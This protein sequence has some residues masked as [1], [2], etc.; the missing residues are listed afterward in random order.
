[1]NL[2]FFFPLNST[3]FSILELIDAQK[4]KIYKPEN[5]YNFWACVLFFIYFVCLFHK[6]KKYIYM[7]F[8]TNI[9]QVIMKNSRNL[10]IGCRLKKNKKFR[11]FINWAVLKPWI[12][13]IDCL[14]KIMN[15]INQTGG[16]SW[17]LPVGWRKKI[18]NFINVSFKKLQVSSNNHWKKLSISWIIHWTRSRRD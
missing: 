12:L 3:K 10:P 13:P 2:F 9:F 7:F 16:K 6:H 5:W 17:I 18:L 1:M 4:K 11:N 14:K 8:F 15:F